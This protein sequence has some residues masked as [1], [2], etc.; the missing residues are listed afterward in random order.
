[1]GLV[2][3]L[4]AVVVELPDAA[5]DDQRR[6]PEQ[7]HQ[8]ACVIQP[9]MTEIT[10]WF[11]DLFARIMSRTGPGPEDGGGPFRLGDASVGDIPLD[12]IHHFALLPPPDLR[13]TAAFKPCTRALL[14]T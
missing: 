8:R 14:Q 11:H 1:M 5:R 3:V 9:C 7:H 13:R 12:L 6:D 10:L 4:L 2:I